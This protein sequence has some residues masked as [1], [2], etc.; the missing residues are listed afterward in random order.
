MI[1]RRKSCILK[2]LKVRK[3]KID[4]NMIVGVGDDWNLEGRLCQYER[5]TY[6]KKL[7]SWLNLRL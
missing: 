2:V 6:Y 1:T 3:K 5:N 4:R 7:V